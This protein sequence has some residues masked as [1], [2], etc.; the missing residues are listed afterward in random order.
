MSGLG[1]DVDRVAGGALVALVAA[2]EGASVPGGGGCV[3]VES[4]GGYEAGPE[5]RGRVAAD[6][7]AGENGWGSSACFRGVDGCLFAL[8]P[9]GMRCGGGAFSSEPVIGVRDG[10]GSAVRLTGRG[11]RDR[12]PAWARGFVELLDVA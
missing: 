6:V 11:V 12:E 7:P 2:V 10:C 5:S 4:V 3:A 9:R 8:W 1:L